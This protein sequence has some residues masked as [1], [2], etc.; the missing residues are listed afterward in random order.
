MPTTATFATRLRS[1]RD[2]AGLT[3][4]ALADRAG[5]RVQMLSRLEQGGR[6]DP[7]WSTVCGLATALEVS[8][9]EFRA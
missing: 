7:R 8:T 9:E 3:Q 5:M 4:Q 2:A 6:S 1:L